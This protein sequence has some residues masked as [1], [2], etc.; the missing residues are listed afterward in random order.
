[1]GKVVETWFYQRL[2]RV[3]YGPMGHNRHSSECK[4]R[5]DAIFSRRGKSVGP[6]PKPIADGEDTDYEASIA[7]DKF[8]R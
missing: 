7:P 3:H 2:P 1:M 6:T 8:P 5:F 4:A